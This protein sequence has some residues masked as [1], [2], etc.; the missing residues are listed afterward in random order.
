LNANANIQALATDNSDNVYAAGYF[1]NG[2]LPS[3]GY[4]YVEKWNGTSWI[5]LGDMALAPAPIFVNAS[6][7]L[8]SV[9]ASHDGKTF[10]V[11]VHD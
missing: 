10:C 6:G 11:V 2:N 9:I 3:T 7:K 1:T 4:R 8:Y 5:D